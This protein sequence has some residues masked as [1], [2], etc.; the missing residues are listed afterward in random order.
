MSQF[1]FDGYTVRSV[2]SRDSDY[3][4]QLIEADPYH[5][6]RMTAEFFTQLLPGEDAWALED[7]LGRVLF[8]FKTSVACRID[9]QFAGQSKHEN[10]FGLL[11]G[12]AWLEGVLV[13]NRFRELFFDPD[14][15]EL[16]QFAKRRLGFVE[17]TP[18]LIKYLGLPTK[19]EACDLD[20]RMVS[21]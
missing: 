13:R 12:M 1:T 9:I 11:R 18:K 21:Q 15:P 14:G 8:Y 17:A 2:E 6:G 16:A 5:R 10:M 7:P 4:N 20:E 3:I 19:K